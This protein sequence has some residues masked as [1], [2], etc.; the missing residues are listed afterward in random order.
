MELVSNDKILHILCM[1]T[2]WEWNMVDRKLYISN[3]E[4]SQCILFWQ[5]PWW[6]H[7]VKNNTRVLISLGVIDVIEVFPVS[8]AVTRGILFTD[9]FFIWTT[10]VCNFL[11]L[12][13][14]DQSEETKQWSVI[15][16]TMNQSET[17]KSVT[18]VTMNNQWLNNSLWLTNSH[19]PWTSQRLNNSIWLTNR[20][21]TY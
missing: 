16:V 6:C 21:K 9:L 1:T 3:N 7:L 11:K 14:E 17:R 4:Q 12:N 10:D 2:I 19:K 15:S 13:K 8:G 20:S 18:S 5:L